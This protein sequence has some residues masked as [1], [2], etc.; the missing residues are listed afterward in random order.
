M[1]DRFYTTL[2]ISQLHDHPQNSKVFGKDLDPE[3]V[4]SIQEIGIINPLVVSQKTGTKYLIISGHSRKYAAIKLGIESVPCLVRQDLTDPLDI[5]DAW[6]EANV[7][8]KMTNEQTARWIAARESV[9][10]LRA[11]ARMKAGGDPSRNSDRGRALDKAAAEVG[12]KRDKA[13]DAKKVV[14][15]IDTAEESGD[16]EKAK[17]LR[18]TLNSKSVNAAKKKV[19]AA[20]P[21]KPRK[22]T[23][24]K[25][26][27]PLANNLLTKHCSPLSRGID[28]LAGML[29]WKKQTEQTGNHQ[30]AHRALNALIGALKAMKEGKL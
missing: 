12:W 28:D 3:I 25:N 4:S 15:A 29:G 23:V 5:D 24:E 7:Q 6:A 9:E 27:V 30:E 14:Q 1:P 17:E 11:E 10:K 2:P 21:K 8:R 26:H 13:S 20:K 19:D 22:K 18:E 16:T